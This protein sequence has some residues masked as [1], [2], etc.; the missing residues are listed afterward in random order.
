M[1]TERGVVTGGAELFVPCCLKTLSLRN[2]TEEIVMKPSLFK[3][4]LLA[5]GLV[6]L[7][8]PVAAETAATQTPA[9]QPQS[10]Q[11]SPAPGNVGAGSG[12]WH[13]W[14]E[15]RQMQ[16]QMNRMFEDAYSRMRSELSS[17][18]PQTQ[19]SPFVTE[20][21]VTVN[22][23]KHDYVVTAD[24]PGVK[25]GD[26]NVSLDGRLLRISAQSRSEENL[27]GKH[28]KVVGEETYASSYQRAL[29]LPGP[30]DASGMHTSFKDGV[31]TVTVP[32]A[33]A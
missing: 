31:L 26:V 24:M 12:S 15:M 1:K 33:T 7:I 3:R 14:Q 11:Q 27:K 8:G 19:S 13:P 4:L 18:H 2:F 23:Q 20:S 9:S 17:S 22:D 16:H 29:T 25:K 6:A 30:V 5:L 28:G 32:K 21:K 10:A